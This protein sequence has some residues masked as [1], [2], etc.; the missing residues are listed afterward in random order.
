MVDG[1]PWEMPSQDLVLRSIEKWRKL[2]LRSITPEIMVREMGLLRRCLGQDIV[3]RRTSSSLDLW[4]V[5]KLDPGETPVSHAELWEP[6]PAKARLSRCNPEG[7]PVLYCSP[8][9]S[10]ALEESRVRV[11]DRVLLVRYEAL[12]LRLV[13][14]VGDFEP[15]TIDGARILSD[16]G[17][18]AYQILR[19]FLRAEFTQVVGD[20]HRSL[21][22]ISS[23]ICQVWRD[24]NGCDGWIYPSAFLPTAENVAVQVPAA[25]EK[26]TVANAWIGTVENTTNPS[27]TIP[28]FHIVVDGFEVSHSAIGRLQPSHIDW[29]PAPAGSRAIF[30]REPEFA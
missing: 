23:A 26:L 11:G 22:C 13:Q 30:S 1:G 10:T 27:V 4:R 28:G 21:Y 16:E 7:Q 3:Q 18:R 25:R 8:R 12:M 29:D 15:R 14:I 6:P 5:R 19:E 24:A 20:E 9:A 17:L 2:R